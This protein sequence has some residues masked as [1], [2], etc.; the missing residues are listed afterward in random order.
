[1]PRKLVTPAAVLV[2]VL[3]AASVLTA[4]GS[5]DDDPAPT[6]RAD[7]SGEEF[8]DADV[9]F[10]TDM[11][12]H[13]AQALVMVDLTM[14]RSLAPEVQALAEGIRA[15]QSPEIEQ[16]SDWLTT[17]GEPIP[18]TVRDHTN[19]HGGGDG[20]GMEMDAEMP[21]MMS[22]DQ[23]AELETADGAEFEQLWLEMMTEHHEGAIEMARTEQSEG[24]FGPAVELAGT[25][26]STQQDEI[27]TMA[28]LLTS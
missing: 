23:M 12:Q 21:G 9:E 3:T 18:E 15:A 13:H 16:M 20:D 1:M 22:A 25:I 8:N 7:S 10:A 19:A 14:G 11:I 5:T 26:E 24:S 2:A 6:A 4:C 28:G 17:W 27:E